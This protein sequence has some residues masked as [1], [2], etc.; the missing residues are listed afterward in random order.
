MKAIHA[1]PVCCTVSQ[2]DP[3]GAFRGEGG[4]SRCWQK[5]PRSWQRTS[6]KLSCTFGTKSKLAVARAEVSALSGAV[7]G[8]EFQ[9]GEKALLWWMNDPKQCL[10]FISQCALS[11]P[12]ADPGSVWGLR[13]NYT[14]TLRVLVLSTDLAVTHTDLWSLCISSCWLQFSAQQCRWRE[15]WGTEE[16]ETTT[17]KK[18]GA[19]T[20]CTQF[21]LVISVNHLPKCWGTSTVLSL[22]LI[23]LWFADTEA[24]KRDTLYSLSMTFSQHTAMKC[25]RNSRRTP[26][27]YVKKFPAILFIQCCHLRT[28]LAILLRERTNPAPLNSLPFHPFGVP[29]ATHP[30]P[31]GSDAWTVRVGQTEPTKK[32]EPQT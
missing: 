7:R 9:L 4:R 32:R 8:K 6:S 5:L 2:I 26:N 22:A 25:L 21:S 3:S 20:K 28:I 13:H 18:N 29:M 27:E 19:N 11:C 16:S 23:V 12:S 10:Q 30:H 31:G 24:P 17:W 1:S 14:S 15:K